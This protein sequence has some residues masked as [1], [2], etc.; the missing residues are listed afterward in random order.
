MTTAARRLLVAG[1][2]LCVWE[3]PAKAQD[4]GSRHIFWGGIGLGY[5]IGTSYCDSC[6]ASRLSGWTFSGDLGVVLNPHMLVGLGGGFWLNGLR[7]GKLPTISTGTL[8][9]SYYLRSQGGPF[10]EGGVGL[11]NYA[12]EHGTGDPLEPV[13][14][15]YSYAAGTGGGYRLGVGWESL[16]KQGSS[17]TVRVA[18]A[19][20]RI[21]SLH[22]PA[23][24]TVA[25]GWRQSV[26]LVE[27]GGRGWL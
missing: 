2:L 23:G 14:R 1:L 3:A 12:L 21:G 11:L 27:L 5:G 18:Y 19:H 15:E 9:L 10:V 16:P 22:D 4:D 8:S 17:T 13:S 6:S 25:T 26:L 7:R 24:A 20:G